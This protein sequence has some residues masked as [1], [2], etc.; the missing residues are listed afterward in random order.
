MHLGNALDI[1]RSVAVCPYCQ[2][3]LSFEVEEWDA[4]TGVPTETGV[5]VSCTN[6]RDP[7]INHFDMPYVY[8]LPMTMQVYDWIVQEGIR[9]ER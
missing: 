9:V 7:Q 6:E 3:D 2:G 8:W 5:M 4:A 1:P